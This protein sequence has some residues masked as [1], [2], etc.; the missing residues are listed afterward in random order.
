MRCGKVSK[1]TK[2]YGPQKMSML[3][4]ATRVCGGSEFG[5]WRKWLRMI[6]YI[7]NA[8]IGIYALKIC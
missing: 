4:M 2:D 5:S 1:A 8:N 3:G 7:N 6:K